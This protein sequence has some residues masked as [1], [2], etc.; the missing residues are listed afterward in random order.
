[1]PV[2]A[3]YLRIASASAVLSIGMAA[4]A[5]NRQTPSVPS[6]AVKLGSIQQTMDL[7]VD[8][9]ADALWESIGTSQTAMGIQVKAPKNDAEWQKVAGYAQ[10]LIAGS[11]RLQTPKLPVGENAH[12][13][14]A[15]A[16]TP[17][18]RTAVQIRV[19]IDAD[20]AKFKAAA[21]RL[22]EASNA[23]LIAARSR[24]AQGVLAAGA[25]L[26][27]A[28]EACHAAYWY[29]RTKPLRLPSTSEFEKNAIGRR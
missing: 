9:S 3:T 1:M 16:D 14:L 21:M 28:C 18:T 4:I 5:A 29:P 25:A 2:N 8:P 19:D 13:K 6:T 22:E 7:L 15:D 10:G 20:P 26:D 17:G 11:K 27:A 12:S 24:D 23:A